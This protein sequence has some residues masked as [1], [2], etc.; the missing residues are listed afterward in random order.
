MYYNNALGENMSGL[1]DLGASK[2]AAPQPIYNP[3]PQGPSM[4]SKLLVYGGI[5]AVVL[6]GGYIVYRKFFKKGR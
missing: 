4:F 6:G 3:P 5:G 1:G 2:R